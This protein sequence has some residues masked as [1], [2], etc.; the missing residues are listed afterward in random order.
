MIASVCA[1]YLC[2]Q[3]IKHFNLFLTNDTQKSQQHQKPCY[4]T[5]STYSPFVARKTIFCFSFLCTCYTCI[6]RSLTLSLS[7]CHTLPILDYFV[8]CTV[9]FV[10]HIALL[11]ATNLLMMFKCFL[12]RI[13]ISQ[14]SIKCRSTYVGTND[15]DNA[16]QTLCQYR[17]HNETK[18][19]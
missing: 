12:V 5:L 15:T 19:C 10:S 9:Q 18:E 4:T 16:K 1:E 2:N 3:S 11:Y 13:F 6:Y 14:S 17:P 7:F 8:I